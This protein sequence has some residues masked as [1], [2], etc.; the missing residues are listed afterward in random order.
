MRTSGLSGFSR[1]ENQKNTGKQQENTIKTA[2]AEVH[3]E[4]RIGFSKLFS[5]NPHHRI[6]RQKFP[7]QSPWSCQDICLPQPPL[8]V[9]Q[10]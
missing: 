10:Q 4:R 7:R 1:P 5:E 6:D 2:S 8:A 3:N 9:R